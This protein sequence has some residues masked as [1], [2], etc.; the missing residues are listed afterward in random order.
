MYLGANSQAKSGS[1]LSKTSGNRMA[2]A[3][4]PQV[5]V[6]VA[7]RNNSDYVS[8]AIESV[9]RQTIRDIRV[10]VVDDASTDDSHDTIRA[11]LSRL[12]DPRFSYM[13][14][15]DCVGQSGAIQYGLEDLDAPFVCFLDSDDYWYEDFL[16]RHLAAHLNS[17]FPVALTYCDSHIV[18][19]EGKLLAGTAWWF[20][21]DA[22]AEGK[23]SLER[24]VIPQIEPKAGH[25]IYDDKPNAILHPSWSPEWSSNS[26]ASM[27]FRRS[28]VDLVMTPS[29]DDLRLYADF[30]LSTMAAL[31]TG[32]IAIPQALYAY[33]MH[34]RNLH[35]NG[36]VLGGPYNSSKKPWEPI[37]ASVLQRILNVLQHQSE[38]LRIAFG[39]YRCEQAMLQI[40]ASLRN[41]LPGR[42]TRGRHRLQELLRGG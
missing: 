9:A 10:V 22:N 6:V 36:S 32:T 19:P 41:G 15:Q 27:M 34:G 20:D 26:M 35:S 18:N 25:A 40:R 33:R 1:I 2:I 39:E 4:V 24:S 5:N 29:L 37:R 21:H 38:P 11:V 31:L 28:F 17:D 42:V 3:E 14:L 16:A 12:D 30:Y 23:R 13:R 8:D 7:N